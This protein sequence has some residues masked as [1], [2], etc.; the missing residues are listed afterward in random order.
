MASN[1]ERQ[2]YEQFE[3]AQTLYFQDEYDQALDLLSQLLEKKL[4]KPLQ[5]LVYRRK[6]DCLS[7][8]QRYEEAAVCLEQ[9]LTLTKYVPYYRCWVLESLGWNLFKMGKHL[10]A[11]AKY[12]EAIDLVDD[13]D[14][15]DHMQDQCEDI[16]ADY[17][18][19][20]RN[21][22]L[23]QNKAKLHELIKQRL[24]LAESEEADPED[25]EGKPVLKA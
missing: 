18:L 11:L 12:E 17:E 25:F 16:L 24:K 15:L 9:A 7:H 3:Q 4:P 21:K 19:T 10:E 20:K 6:G 2:Y 1:K 8:I 5:A 22:N 23:T 13:Q 14:D